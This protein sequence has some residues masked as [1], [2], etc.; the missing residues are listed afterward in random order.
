[1]AVLVVSPAPTPNNIVNRCLVY[2][3]SLSQRVLTCNTLGIRGT[4]LSYFSQCQLGSLVCFAMSLPLLRKHVGMV[5]G[6]IA[7]KQMVGI[8]TRRIVACVTDVNPV[9]D[10]SAIQ[11]PCYSMGQTGL[12]LKREQP[13]PIGVFASS[14]QPAVVSDG[15]ELLKAPL[16]FAWDRLLGHRNSSFRCHGAGLFAQSRLHSYVGILPW[17]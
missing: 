13:V 2:A 5:V 17:Q 14:P 11:H 9:R 3:K 4:Y 8:H 6:V 12:L 16:D 10:A 1:M 15:D 7:E